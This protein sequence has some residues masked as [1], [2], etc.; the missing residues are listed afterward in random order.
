MKDYLELR[1]KKIIRE[2]AQAITLVLENVSGEPVAYQSGQFLTFLLT[3]SGRELRRSYSLCSSPGIDPDMMI[4][5]TRVINGEVSRYLTEHLQEGDILQSLYPAGRFTLESKPEQRRDIFLIGA[6]S[7]MTPLFSILKT[8]LR[9]VTASHL[10]LIDS[11]KNEATAL[12][13]KPLQTLSRQYSQQFTSIHLFSDPLP[14]SNQ[15]PVRLN[16]SLLE[17]LVNKHLKYEKSEAQFY[18]CGP[19]T[20]MRMVRMTLIFMGFPEESIHK[21]NFITQAQFDITLSRY[22]NTSTSPV[23]LIFRNQ[24]YRVEVPPHSSILKAALSQGIP[25]PYSCMAGMC[26]TCSGK[27]SSGK[28]KM[29]INDVLTDTEVAEGWVLTCVAFPLSTGVTI[30]VE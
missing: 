5:I 14:S 20:F 27:C 28:V 8:A 24:S 11:N 21:E 13:W 9:T 2:T 25:L 22:E 3:I 4:T 6:G 26:A 29:A 30:V 10:T 12:Y 7:G 1:I 17:T 19:S 16:I 15:Y 18:V 23:Q